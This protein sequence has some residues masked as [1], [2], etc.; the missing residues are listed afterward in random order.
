MRSIYR[1]KARTWLAR[2]WWRATH[3]ATRKLAFAAVGAVIALIVAWR[4]DL[5]IAIVPLAVGLAPL[6]ASSVA[7]IRRTVRVDRIARRLRTAS[8]VPA[9]REGLRAIGV[10]DATADR[11]LS[12]GADAE[13]RIAAFDQNNRAVSWIGPIPFFGDALIPESEFRARSRNALELVIY[14]GALCIKKTYRKRSTFEAEVLALDTLENVRGVP[15]LIA[16]DSRAKVSYQSFLPGHNVGTLMAANGTSVS[17]QYHLSVGFD[18]PGRWGEESRAKGR[19]LAVAA[20]TASVGSNGV[21]N[22]GD[23]VTRIHERGV[24]IGDVKYG[25]VLLVDGEP[26]LCDFDGAAL[27]DRNDWRCVRARADDREKFDYFFGGELLS[28][29]KF[30]NA[31][32]ELARAHPSLFYAPTYYGHG[33]ESQAPGSIELGSGKW[34]FIR[35]HLPELAGKSVVDLGCNNALLPLEMLRA[36]ARRVTAYELNSVFAKYA[37]LNHQWFEFVDNVSYDGFELVEGYMHD[38]CERN[39][40]GY[41]VATAF[42]SLY[43]EEPEQMARIVRTLSGDIPCFIVQANENPEEHSGALLER[44]SLRYLSDLLRSNGYPDQTVVEFSYYDRPLVIG[45]RARS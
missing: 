31:V 5:G 19:D 40:S 24:T 10:E 39:W 23:L 27:H 7:S 25:N 28:E 2:S 9:A 29:R 17:T 20:L 22:L 18:D 41:D 33:Y 11:L 44:A 6:I 43:Y 32:A 3:G 36:G 35:S 38:A 1:D 42:C 45:R 34:L 26:H 13:V 14:K 21:A 12:A 30:R 4:G 16:V 15:R 8:P 37:R